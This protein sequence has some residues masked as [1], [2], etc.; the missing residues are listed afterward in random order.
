MMFLLMKQI[1]FMLQ[2]LYNLIEYSNDYSDT[3]ARLWEF[4]RDKV[5]DDNDDLTAD[6]SQS[7]KHKAVPVGKT[8]DVVNN[9]KSSV[10]YTKIV[11]PLKYLSN[12]WRSL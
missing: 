6:N 12:S 9:T 1:I 2:C 3:S 8:V 5:L 7:F 11:V 4:K 10:K